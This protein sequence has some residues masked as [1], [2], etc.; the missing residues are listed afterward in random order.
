M[1]LVGKKEVLDLQGEPSQRDG[2]TFS[3]TAYLASTITL[4]FV[5]W[6]DMGSPRQIVATI[7]L[8]VLCTCGP[9]RE[10]VAHDMRN[11]PHFAGCPRWGTR[12]AA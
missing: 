3:S 11:E 9:G 1:H 6:V 7:E 12:K 4:N 5:R 2:V 8:P 10:S